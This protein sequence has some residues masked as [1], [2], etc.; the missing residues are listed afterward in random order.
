M[1][2]SAMRP[3]MMRC[4]ALLLTCSM[5]FA[6]KTSLHELAEKSL[7]CCS[8]ISA[9]IVRLRAWMNGEP[10]WRTIRANRN[11]PQVSDLQLIRQTDKPWKRCSGSRIAV[12]M[13]PK[14]QA[15]TG[16]FR[17]IHEPGPHQLNVHPDQGSGF[18]GL[19]IT[20][21]DRS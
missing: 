18:T 19:R 1:I 12:Y 4:A 10:C 14:V 16:S 11:G 8:W 21:S 9:E 20:G 7:A 5:R 15:A 17:Q 6:A 3:E 13:W 2:D